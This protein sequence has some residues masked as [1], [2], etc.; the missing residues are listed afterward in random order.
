[1]LP[2]FDNIFLDKNMP[3]RIR[4]SAG[5]LLR[6][7]KFESCWSL[8][9]LF[10]KLCVK[11]ENTLKRGWDGQLKR[12]DR[13]SWVIFGQNTFG[14]ISVEQNLRHRFESRW[15][16]QIEASNSNI[17]EVAAAKFISNFV[18]LWYRLIAKISIL[19]HTYTPQNTKTTRLGKTSFLG[20][21][22][23]DNCNT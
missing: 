20:E 4:R 23:Q 18:E 12:L 1:M 7:S 9:F 19:K 10:C 14:H 16:K 15:S 6:R 13:F 2:K 17:I 11:K 3:N 22:V 21:L 5:L 8:Q